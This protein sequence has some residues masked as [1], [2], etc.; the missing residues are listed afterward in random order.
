MKG[1]D[2]QRTALLQVGGL[3]ESVAEVIELNPS[4]KIRRKE[5]STNANEKGDFAS[6]NFII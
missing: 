6:S 3:E 2:L 5:L 4:V 1:Q